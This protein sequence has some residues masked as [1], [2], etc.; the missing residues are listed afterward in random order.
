MGGLCA[1]SDAL[2][3]IGHAC[4]HNIIA[5]AAVG[6]A[7]ALQPV[8]GELG[9]G[10]RLLGTPAEEV[11]D[12]GGK[13]LM[14]ERGAWDG[15]HVSM[16]VH[17]GPFDD[18]APP[19]I[20]ISA[21]DIAYHGKE[22]HATTFADLGVNAGAAATIAQVA[23]AELRQQLK[24]SQRV[25][26]IIEKFGSSANTLSGYSRLRYMARAGIPGGPGRAQSEGDDG[27]SK[28]GRWPP[29]ASMEVI[30]GQQP[31]A[32]LASDPE[33]AIRSARP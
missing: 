13:I 28:P 12:A 10:I 24:P 16:M 22:V 32:P 7:R 33:V 5:A 29:G 11:G 3:D 30:G 18:L 23:L 31:Y 8:A 26:G 21:F 1:G 2:P 25:H 6:A 17:P 9:M 20:A 15:A 4:G 19:L 27:A 14:L